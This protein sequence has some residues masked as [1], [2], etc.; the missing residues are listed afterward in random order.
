MDF[1]KVATADLKLVDHTLPAD[2][3][4]T[5][6][7]LMKSK[8]TDRSAYFVGCAKWGRDEWKGLI[9]PPETKTADFLNEYAKQFNAIELNASFY[10]VPTQASV[11]SWRLK[12]EANAMGEF[13]FVPKFPKSISHF[14]K[15]QNAEEITERFVHAV[16]GL[17]RY[18]GPCFLQ[19]SDAFA[20]KDFVILE[21]Y[22]RSL[23]A[24][25]RLFVELRNS[26]WF[27]DTDTRASVVKLFSELNVGWVIT[28]TSGRRDL[29]HMEFST[30]EAFIRFEGNGKDMIL[31]DTKRIEE[32]VTR[33]KSWVEQGLK[34][35][36]F[37]LH[38]L[39]EADTPKLASITVDEL[40]KQLDA[41]LQPIR[42]IS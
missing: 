33:I 24:E 4:S 25:L 9:Y 22:L 7:M 18:L 27:A 39:D 37:F 26:G 42:F 20:P 1:G 16:A 35:V 8:K 14:K 36:Y 11:E 28:D 34:T 23:P 6:A 32:W 5:S 3:V 2:A 30:P 40:N 13:A 12:V 19:L 41:G 10:K 21:N 38:Q 15:L 29:L 17:G 31:S